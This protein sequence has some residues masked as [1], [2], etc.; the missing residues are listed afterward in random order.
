MNVAQMYQKIILKLDQLAINMGAILE[1]SPIKK[2]FIIACFL[3]IIFSQ[4]IFFDLLFLIKSSPYINTIILERF[5]PVKLIFMMTTL[6][7]VLLHKKLEMSHFFQT[8]LP[9]IFTVFYVLSL[10]TL[11]YVVGHLSIATGVVI[12]ATPLFFMIFFD[13]TVTATL[14]ISGVLSFV[15][16]C[17]LCITGVLPYAPLFEPIAQQDHYG[18]LFYSACMLFFILPFLIVFM[19]GTY[20]LV[21]FWQS[22]E[23]NVRKK[24]QTDDLIDM[25]N[26]RAISDY[27]TSTSTK[28]V[29][30]EPLSIILIDIDHF[31]KV[32]DIYGHSTG[33]LVLQYV[34]HSLKASIRLSDQV[35]RYGG[36]EF[37]LVLEKTPIDVAQQIAERCRLQ[38]EKLLIVDQH[39]NQIPVTASFGIYCSTRQESVS[40]MIHYADIQLYRAKEM[41]R[42]CVCTHSA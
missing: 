34:G 25:A 8:F 12:A 42:N 17:I 29:A 35:G 18:Q 21:K 3:L 14:I 6:M 4:Y 27:L 41:G 7:M 26:R 32:N 22:R 1:L 28:R 5:L 20:I 37:L 2:S 38:I 24:S 13:Y 23:D 39:D 33:D 30:F 9:Y 36:E 40:E 10:M 16:I 31:K 19:L 15:L 11:G